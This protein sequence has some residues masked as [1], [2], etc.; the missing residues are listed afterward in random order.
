MRLICPNCGAQYEVPDD[1]IPAAGRDVQCS[2]CGHTWLELPGASEAAEAELDAVSSVS[3]AD[4]L[5]DTSA[6]VTEDEA[7][8]S[9][10]FDGSIDEAFA[11]ISPADPPPDL[12]DTTTDFE[13]AE[14]EETPTTAPRRRPVDASVSAILQEE[15]AR[16][17]AARKSEMAAPLE[18]QE[19]LGLPP[20]PAP[21][22]RASETERLVREMQQEEEAAIRDADD[23]DALGAAATPTALNTTVTSAGSR[24]ELLPDIEEINSSLRSNAERGDPTIPEPEEVEE[25]R[26]RGF[27]FGFFTVLIV[28]I[29]FA[30]LYIFAPEISQAVPSFA[31]ALDAYVAGVDAARIWLD[32]QVQALLE[33]IRPEADTPTE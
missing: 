21:Q 30:L 15:A 13:S 19:D 29:I 6:S 25:E 31:G 16:E 4:T 11:D 23:G 3:V 1:V 7:N 17:V 12:P 9:K 28:I 10:S 20:E 32:V 14:G 33:M 2:N 22:Q 26:R 27:R 24:K 8:D 18:Q 5:A